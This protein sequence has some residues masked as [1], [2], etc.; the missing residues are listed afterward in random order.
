M[1]WQSV[2]LVEFRCPQGFGPLEFGKELARSEADL[3]SLNPDGCSAGMKRRELAGTR[4]PNLSKTAGTIL[5]GAMHEASEQRR[6]IL[7]DLGTT[8]EGGAYC[9]QWNNMYDP[10]VAAA[11]TNS[12]GEIAGGSREGS[13][14][15]SRA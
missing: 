14:P 9:V 15:D 11:P 6:I 3:R 10:A 2:R 7:F 5:C 13:Q 1:T 12:A 8:F 4:R